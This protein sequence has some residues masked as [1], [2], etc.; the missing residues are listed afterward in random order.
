MPP[1]HQQQPRGLETERQHPWEPLFPSQ[2][3]H[4][5]PVLSKEGGENC[6]RVGSKALVQIT[7]FIHGP[8]LMAMVRIRN[9]VGAM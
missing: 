3:S 7:L 9:P 1:L 8:S 2:G 4:P 5:L 6:M